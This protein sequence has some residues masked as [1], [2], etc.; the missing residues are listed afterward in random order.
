MNAITKVYKATILKKQG[1]LSALDL[2]LFA[3]EG[4]G[5][6]HGVGASVPG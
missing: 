6:G 1:S 5:A 2:G 3:S 4:V